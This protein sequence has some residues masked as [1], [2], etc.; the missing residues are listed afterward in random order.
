M[1][2]P[3]PAFTTQHFND[4]D[5]SLR[6]HSPA[7]DIEMA[8][9]DG[10]DTP[11]EKAPS[12]RG[13]HGW[14]WAVAVASIL[15]ST[16]LFSLDNTIVADVQPAIFERFDE[17]DTLPWLGVAFALGSAA[18]IL[19]WCKAYGVFNIKWLYIF[20][21]LLFEVGSALCGGANTMNTLIVGRAIA[22]VGGCG[23]YVGCL[24][25]LSVT[26]SMQERPVYMGSTGLI[27][28]VGTVLGPVVGGAFADSSATWRWAFYI[29]LVIG[30]IFAS[31]FFFLLPSIDLQVGVPLKEKILKMT[32]WFGIAVFNVFIICFVMAVSFGGTYYEW[33]SGP[34]ITFWVLGG[35]FFVA[36]CFTQ[37]PTYYIPLFFQFALGE[38]ALKAAVR[39]LPFICMLVLFAL[40]NGGLMAKFGYYMPWYLFGGALILVG[41]SLMYTLD[42]NTSVSA[43]YGY[44]VLI[45][46]GTGSFLQ[47]SYGVSQ[48]LVDPE[49]IPNAIGFIGIGQNIGVVLFL[50]VAGTI[51]NNEAIK[52]VTPI[53]VGV[54]EPEV[55]GA[56]AGTSSSI[57]EN[58]DEATRA[59][60]VEAII[61]SLDK[62]YGIIIAGGALV[63][64][65]AFFLLRQK[66]FMTATAAG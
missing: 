47:A 11:P 15:S 26:T 48:A 42:S 44:S 4:K 60:V 64:I 43:V 49:D 24:T 55:E 7:T 41:S 9:L 18:T 20:H 16:F 45:G 29:N 10:S 50:A 19:P 36:F 2:V 14:K 39:L 35:V 65:L 63:F 31:A 38:S 23:M 25:Y 30:A 52:A 57:F 21:V 13:V 40:L 22:G 3:D 66:L 53:L 37:T 34:E 51:F 5:S 12:A 61:Q 8:T 27:W 56:I 6:D 1:D 59:R 28:G 33:N 54:S 62:V 17:I 46:I 32:D 58:L